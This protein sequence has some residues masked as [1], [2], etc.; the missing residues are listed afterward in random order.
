MTFFKKN[1]F[2]GVEF[3]PKKNKNKSTYTHIVFLTTN[4]RFKFTTSFYNLMG[5]II[6]SMY[7]IF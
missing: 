2:F 7:K 4:V 1:L 6:I 3:F 5:G